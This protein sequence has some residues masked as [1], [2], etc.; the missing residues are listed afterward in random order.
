MDE[1]LKAL[2]IEKLD[3]SQITALKE[4]IESIVD[5]KARERADSLLKDE[6]EKLVEEYEGKF[7]EYKTDITSKFS[8]FVDTVLEEE[9]KLPEKVVEYAKKGELYD[10]VI[11]T[12]KTRLAIDEG[13]L[14]EEVKGLLREA[15]EE[16]LSLR[17]GLNEE[18]GKRMAAEEDAKALAAH[19]YLRKKCDGLT[20]AQRTKVI[21]LLGDL[22][23]KK[24]I[25]NKFQIVVDTILSEMDGPMT[26]LKPGTEEPEPEAKTEDYICPSCGVGFTAKGKTACPSCGA[27]VKDA[28]DPIPAADMG[29]GKLEVDNL[30]GKKVAE[31]D[32][33][34]W[35]KYVQNAVKILKEN[36]F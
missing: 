30:E 18:I 22:T 2:G 24:D 31:S 6:S 23:E 4:K 21:N 16:I 9:L 7:E 1:I 10:E 20:E 13:V 19:L 29:Q 15:K 25:D 32:T 17:E 28:D 5:V 26:G 12:L 36:N 27:A 35:D 3:E 33:T 11:Q 8:N 34:P 14:N